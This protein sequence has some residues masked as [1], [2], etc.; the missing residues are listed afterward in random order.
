MERGH[1]AD[2]S[3]LPPWKQAQVIKPCGSNP[4]KILFFK[5]PK[6]VTNYIQI[7]MKYPSS[8]RVIMVKTI[9]LNVYRLSLS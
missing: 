2:S 4:E 9:S 5:L 7:I 1:K 8:L 3:Q 6:M